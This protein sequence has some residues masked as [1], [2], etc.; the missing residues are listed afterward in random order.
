ME[1]STTRYTL[2]GT[3]ALDLFKRNGFML[4]FGRP[5]MRKYAINDYGRYALYN[6]VLL[7]HRNPWR[8]LKT[9]LVTGFN[10]YFIPD[11]PPGNYNIP[12]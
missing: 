12:F 10:P 5:F 1:R 9:F 4:L 6:K 7:Y 2:A 8:F 11:L 3:T